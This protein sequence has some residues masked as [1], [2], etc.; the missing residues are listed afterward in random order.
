MSL[1]SVVSITKVIDYCNQLAYL[2]NIVIVIDY[3]E[4]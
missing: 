3:F 2:S 4:K 1:T